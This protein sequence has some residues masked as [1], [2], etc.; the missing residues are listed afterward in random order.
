MNV[1]VSVLSYSTP[2]ATEQAVDIRW[3]SW[4]EEKYDFLGIAHTDIHT[5]MGTAWHGMARHGNCV[6]PH[7]SCMSQLP[8]LISIGQIGDLELGVSM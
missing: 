6:H 5:Y 2:P 4:I 3:A 7:A 8:R 1:R